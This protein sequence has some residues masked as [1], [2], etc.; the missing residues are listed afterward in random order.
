LSW[1]LAKLENVK[2]KIFVINLARRPDRL[3]AI[4]SNLEKFDL[5]FERVEAVDA[6]INP[7]V[8][9]YRRPLLSR[10]LGKGSYRDG[11]IANYLSHRSVW[12]QMVDE[13]ISQALVLEDDAQIVNWDGNFLTVDLKSLGVDILRLGAN[14]EPD[15][16]DTER[17][18]HVGKTI[19][20][21]EMIKGRLWGNVATI[22]TRE[23]AIKFLKVKKYWFPSDHYHT[24]E[25]C[26]GV[27]HVI[28]T[29]LLWVTTDSLS[30]VH[31][32]KQILSTPQTFILF[33][34]KRLRRIAIYPMLCWFLK[35]TTHLKA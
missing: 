7:I 11:I 35:V 28:V 1:C 34:T 30:D 13:N 32:Q 3:A 25:R 9:L 19:L 17:F 26:F 5:T 15:L 10:V 27:T 22:I 8:K 18:K 20:G 24:Y 6:K 4:T 31:I 21:R 23:A 12:Q 14:A 2:M 29:P 33:F 16:G